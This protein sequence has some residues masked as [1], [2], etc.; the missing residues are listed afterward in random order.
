MQAYPQGQQTVINQT[1]VTVQP[2][3]QTVIQVTQVTGNPMMPR[4]PP[5][6]WTTDMC[7]CC[8]DM[9]ICLCATFVPCYPCMLAADMDESCCV[10]MCIP[11]ALISMRAVVRSRHNI[12]GNLMNDCVCMTFCGYCVTCQLGREV[13]MIK[14]GRAIP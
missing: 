2:A 12:T 7:R 6:D 1:A 9:T 5:R 3:A 13:Q 4:G 10:P 14:N 8:D 11:S